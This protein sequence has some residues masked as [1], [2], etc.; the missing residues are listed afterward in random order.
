M[1]GSY[2]HFS[3]P[4]SAGMYERAFKASRSTVMMWV[5]HHP[6]V[7]G[8]DT[9]R[10]TLRCAA[11][12][13]EMAE[14]VGAGEVGDEEDVQVITLEDFMRG[15]SLREEDEADDA[16]EAGSPLY[17][18]D[19]DIGEHEEVD[20]RVQAQ[21]EE[22]NAA[23]QAVNDTELQL[24][25]AKL[26]LKKVRSDWDTHCQAIMKRLRGAVKTSAPYF[27]QQSIGDDL[28]AR[29]VECNA[30]YKLAKE[31]HDNA[32]SRLHALESGFPHSSTTA[33]AERIEA[34]IEQLSAATDAVTSAENRK[35]IAYD[36]HERCAALASKAQA[37]VERLRK[38][39][40]NAIEKARPFFDAKAQAERDV[41]QQSRRVDALKQQLQGA[42]N[43]YAN[44]MRVLE[45]ISAQVHEQ[46]EARRRDDADGERGHAELQLEQRLRLQK[47]EGTSGDFQYWQ[48]QN[49]DRDRQGV[50]ASDDDAQP[51][52]NGNI[53]VNFG[54]L[55]EAPL[56]KSTM[57]SNPFDELPTFDGSARNEDDEQYRGSALSS[58]YIAFGDMNHHSAWDEHGF[59][60]APNSLGEGDQ[61]RQ[62]SQ[63]PPQPRQHEDYPSLISEDAL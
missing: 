33:P 6:D 9:C 16:E 20:P 11:R 32:R 21:L 41:E 56:S 50:E 45:R 36:R 24:S 2:F 60:D 7:Q 54:V 25:N 57:H 12:V 5:A 29:M 15:V 34:T 31:E 58:D 10:K 48:N 59:H 53:A 13:P 35:R 23:M 62:D 37:E 47:E 38:Q 52:S 3:L 46:R 27:H 55:E 14:E 42:K 44:A 30:E 51:A 40:R 61:F 28:K 26:E 39:H 17:Q 8:V 18:P 43:R 1:E 63:L 22:L 19:T 49:E 4:I